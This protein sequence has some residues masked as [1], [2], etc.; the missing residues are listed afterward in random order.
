MYY[1]QE[2]DKLNF[3]DKIFNNVRLEQDKLILPYIGD[4]EM[5]DKK[6]RRL[7][8]K[9]KKLLSEASCNKLVL[10]KKVQNQEMYVNY[11]HSN[12][13]EIINGKWLFDIIILEVL[14]YLIKKK[15]MKEKEVQISILVNDLSE[16]VLENIKKIVR[17]Y[18]KVNVVTNH[19]S[20]FKKIEKEILDEY[21]VMM[22]V[23][24]N[25]RKS[26]SKSNIVLN[27][28]FPIEII[29]KYLIYDKAI[30]IN[31]KGNVKINSKRFNG[32]NINDYEVKY[33]NQ[34]YFDYD[35]ETKYKSKEIYESLIYKKQP[36]KQILKRIKKDKLEITQLIGNNSKI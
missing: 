22:I 35:K 26:L 25:K 18:K 7:G 28:D 30:I 16:N 36:L 29:N 5:L 21:G 13:F 12:G 10:S 2:T 17:K 8:I 1:I 27:I 19:I 15:K 6:A 34:N 32:I 20:K 3:F 31:F 4:E 14:K 9:T 33:H 23:G 24:D 11:L